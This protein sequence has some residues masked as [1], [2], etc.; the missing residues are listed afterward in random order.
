MAFFFFSFLP[1]P[2]PSNWY[3]EMI[4]ERLADVCVEEN[5]YGLLSA[6]A[7]DYV[8]IQPKELVKQQQQLMVIIRAQ[9][10]MQRQ[11]KRRK[12][13]IGVSPT[14]PTCIEGGR[15]DQQQQ[16]ET[17]KSTTS[18]TDFGS[19]LLPQS[20]TSKQHQP[21]V[22][23]TKEQEQE[24]EE[25][26]E[27]EEEATEG[28]NAG[29]KNINP[30]EDEQERRILERDV[31]GQD[32]NDWSL[33]G[34]VCKDEALKEAQLMSALL[35][36]VEKF[37][38]NN[39]RE[40]MN[41]FQNRVGNVPTNPAD[42]SLW[43]AGA[44]PMRLH[45]TGV[46]QEIAQMQIQILSS[47]NIQKRLRLAMHLTATCIECAQKRSKVQFWII[48]TIIAMALLFEFINGRG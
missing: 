36:K 43:V 19:M 3:N 20:S 46:Y 48:V 35:K 31:T 7:E 14:N 5:S 9:Q 18:N 40:D 37:V 12:K 10:Q 29:K 4:L 28:N 44:L 6:V 8:D 13:S 16:Q 27:E 11:L 47:R 39:E 1:F 34:S 38:Q 2:V 15:M 22:A 26:E 23:N 25:E 32:D 24:Q 42:F 17:E 30:N 41:Q 33:G 45:N 21:H